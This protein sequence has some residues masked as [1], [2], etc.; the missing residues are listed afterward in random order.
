[1]KRQTDEHN[2]KFLITVN[3]PRA[4]VEPYSWQVIKEQYQLTDEIASPYEINDVM[5]R[6]A[7]DAGIY[8]H[9]G[10]LEAIEWERRYGLLHFVKDGHFNKNGNL[11]MGTKVADF[12]VGNKII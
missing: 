4:Q 8:F 1:M 9:D 11:F 5:G 7:K 3:I 10:R 6:I 12:I 2:A